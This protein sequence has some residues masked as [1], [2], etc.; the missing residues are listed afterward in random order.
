MIYRIWTYV[1]IQSRAQEAR[2]GFAQGHCRPVSEPWSD[3]RQWRQ[4]QSQVEQRELRSPGKRHRN[5]PEL[6]Q[7][8]KVEQPPH[9]STT[10]QTRLDSCA[11]PSD[12]GRT[13]TSSS[14]TRSSTTT[15]AS[16]T[17]PAPAPLTSTEPKQR[18]CHRCS[19]RS[20]FQRTCFR[21]WPKPARHFACSSPKPHNYARPDP[22][23]RH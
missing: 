18:C 8:T 16:A 5:C 4:R 13:S 23:R 1:R 22:C 2:Q 9:P 15:A 7:A 3:F 17:T 20:L 10:S 14:S 6:A 12:P 11:K 21:R 19:K